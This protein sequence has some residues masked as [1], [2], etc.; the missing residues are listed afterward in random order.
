MRK[1]HK[2][3]IRTMGPRSADARRLNPPARRCLIVHLARPQVQRAV[4]GRAMIAD[5]G[6]YARGAPFGAAPYGRDLFYVELVGDRLEGH[7]FAAQ[8]GDPLTEFGVVCDACWPL[9]AGGAHSVAG[10]L[11][12]SPTLPA[13]DLD[14]RLERQASRVFVGVESWGSD[15]EARIVAREP[16]QHPAE[17]GHR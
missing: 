14:D 13:R 10:A 17:V 3:E 4:R 5:G 1:T 11:D 8:L 9:T 7:A 15:Y 16:L 2:G 6:L 12:Q